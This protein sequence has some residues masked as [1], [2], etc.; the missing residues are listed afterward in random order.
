MQFLGIP[1]VIVM[2][3]SGCGAVDAAIKVLKKNAELP[4]HLP[5]LV[6]AIK[7]AVLVAEKTAKGDLLDNAIAENARRQADRIKTSP[8]IMQQAYAAKKIDIVAATY[9]IATGKISLV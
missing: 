5:D 4:G 3:H 9:D 6:R 1:L 2:G 8:P 7:P